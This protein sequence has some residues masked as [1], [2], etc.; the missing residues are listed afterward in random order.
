MSYS[1]KAKSSGN[2]VRC[3]KCG[4]LLAKEKDGTFH[5]RVRVAYNSFQNI[6]VTGAEMI[7]LECPKIKSDM[8]ICGEIKNVGR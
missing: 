2:E 8:S 1:E 3:N 7:T 6:Y 4:R 5:I